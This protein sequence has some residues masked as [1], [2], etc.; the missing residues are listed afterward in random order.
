MTREDSTAAGDPAGSGEAA[1]PADLGAADSN[2]RLV[3]RVNNALA[4]I[5]AFAE[6]GLAREDSE[7]S[8]RALERIAAVVKDLGAALREARGREN[9]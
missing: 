6:A 1:P 7:A 3:H 2:R 4:S 5:L 8:R 9:A